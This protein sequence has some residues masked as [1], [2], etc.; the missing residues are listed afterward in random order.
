MHYMPVAAVRVTP[1]ASQVTRAL[2]PIPKK[3]FN[4]H[5]LARFYLRHSVL[6]CWQSE[7]GLHRPGRTMRDA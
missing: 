3:M 5:A 1:S 4:R 7:Q 6:A 2:P